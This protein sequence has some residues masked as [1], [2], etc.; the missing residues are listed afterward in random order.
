MLSFPLE[1]W[2]EWLISKLQA[3]LLWLN[4]DLQHLQLLLLGLGHTFHHMSFVYPM[5]YIIQCLT[6]WWTNIAMENHHFLMGTSTISMAIFHGK[7]WVHQ[8]VFVY[9]VQIFLAIEFSSSPHRSK[10]SASRSMKPWRPSRRSET[11]SRPTPPDWS[12]VAAGDG[13]MSPG[14][15][16]HMSPGRNCQR[17]FRSHLGQTSFVSQNLRHLM[18][19]WPPVGW[20]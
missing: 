13:E 17:I 16:A 6:L 10:V 5:P 20:C 18:L 8:R 2:E 14:A 7:M 3:I 15:T 1:S 9:L 12:S 19:S 11:P 4:L